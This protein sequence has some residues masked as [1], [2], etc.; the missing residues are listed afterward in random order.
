MATNGSSA[1]QWLAENGSSASPEQL[2]RIRNAIANK[3]DQ[4][5][6]GH[7]DEDGLLEALDVMDEWQDSRNQPNPASSSLNTSD[8]PA[9]VLDTSPLTPDVAPAPQ[10]SP[11]EKRT[12]F[13]ELLSQSQN[14][15]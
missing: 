12:R 14:Q 15:S 6:E 10:L 11:D 4:L 7:P 1:R 9:P 3:L 8:A 2:L 5:P 13:Q